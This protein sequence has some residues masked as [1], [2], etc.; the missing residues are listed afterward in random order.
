ML[1]GS[2]HRQDLSKVHKERPPPIIDTKMRYGATAQLATK[3]AASH[4]RR[5]KEAEIS[6]PRTLPLDGSA[7]HRLT[8]F[9]T[10]GSTV[11]AT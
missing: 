6:G 9:K 4:A 5:L 8:A 7:H 1:A 3:L 11:G 10:V 2:R